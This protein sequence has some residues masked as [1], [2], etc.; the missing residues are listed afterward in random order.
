MLDADLLEHTDQDI[1]NRFRHKRLLIV[2]STAKAMTPA[3]MK[4]RSMAMGGT[5]RG[6]VTAL[7]AIPVARAVAPEG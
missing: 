5:S 3:Q 2:A 4:A 7:E 6:H 1:R